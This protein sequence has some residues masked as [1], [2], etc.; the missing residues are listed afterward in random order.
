MV[1]N[2]DGDIADGSSVAVIVQ[3]QQ[4]LDVCFLLKHSLWSPPLLLVCC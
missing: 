3:I 4:C 2:G 1:V